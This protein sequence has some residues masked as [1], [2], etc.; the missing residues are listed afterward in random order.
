MLAASGFEVIGSALTVANALRLL[1][2]RRPDV[3][4]L[5]LNLRGEI[6]TPVAKA[7]QSKGILFVAVSAYG[8]NCS[9]IDATF[10][11]VPC[12][13][14]PINGAELIAKI[15]RLLAEFTPHHEGDRPPSFTESHQA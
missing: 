4:T 11:Q 9:V 13:A 2:T 15:Y 6:S 8:P 5:D 10:A 14:K 3:A 1:E 12:V 7:L